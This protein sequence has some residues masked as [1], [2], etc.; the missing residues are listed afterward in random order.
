MGLG[1]DVTR[2]K[3]YLQ[4]MIQNRV[5]ATHFLDEEGIIKRKKMM[6]RHI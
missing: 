2:N 6:R 5:A 1:L 3:T 4:K